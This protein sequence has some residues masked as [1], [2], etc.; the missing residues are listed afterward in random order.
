MCI[1][2]AV[3]LAMVPWMPCQNGLSKIS[4]PKNWLRRVTSHQLCN[5]RACAKEGLKGRALTVR[6]HLGL[7]TI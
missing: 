2:F 3:R 6:F 4:V 5:D 1:R 7:F